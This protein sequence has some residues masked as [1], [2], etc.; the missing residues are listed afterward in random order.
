M[1]PKLLFQWIIIFIH[2]YIS[3]EAVSAAESASAALAKPS[4][5]SVLMSPEST[6]SLVG[7]V[8]RREDM[9]LMSDDD[10]K[11]FIHGNTK[12]AKYLKKKLNETTDKEKV[13]V[14]LRQVMRVLNQAKEVYNERFN[15]DEE[16]KE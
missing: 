15:N 7:P 12:K 9:I 16:E 5:R 6:L 3:T 4:P 13:M 14:K 10:L 2:S 8:L 1:R 11:K